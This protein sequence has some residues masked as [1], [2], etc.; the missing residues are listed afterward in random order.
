MKSKPNH[1][2]F[3]SPHKPLL[4]L[5]LCLTLLCSSDG[6]ELLRPSMESLFHN[7]LLPLGTTMYVWGGGWNEEDTGAG[8]EALTLGISPRWKE[9]FFA[10]NTEYD[11]HT[12]KF[13]IHDGLDCSGYIGWLLYNTL[14]TPDCTGYVFPASR[15]VSR[16]ADL[17][18]GTLT[19]DKTWL[20]G[21]ICSMPGHV[22]MCL[23]SCF[24]GS[25]LL[26]HSSPPGVRLCGTG[27][28]AIRLAEGIM[29][30]HSPD[31]F[32]RYP[33]CSVSSDYLETS[34]KLRWHSYIFPDRAD[35]I[36][37]SAGQISN[38]L[39]P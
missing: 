8:T 11:F 22:W 29:S 9:F 10:Q 37:F 36:C 13:Q 21:D 18:L 16:L 24:D 38:L 34:E 2:P 39:F 31:W 6:S 4:A 12:T 35:W 14:R 27:P 32:S 25:V 7:A 33:D 23:G 19:I 20:P 1:F 5:L 30:S 28:Q 26:I 17:H 3:P 15:A